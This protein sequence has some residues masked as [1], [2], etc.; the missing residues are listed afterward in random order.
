MNIT[1]KEDARQ[2]IE[3]VVTEYRQD[4]TRTN[5]KMITR[6]GY[7]LQ[8]FIVV[9]MSIMIF[10]CILK[11]FDAEHQLIKWMAL[12]GAG[13]GVI[14]LS[15]ILYTG[16]SVHYKEKIWCSDNVS[17]THVLYMCENTAL[18]NQIRNHLIQGYSITYSF[19]NDNKDIMLSRIAAKSQKELW[20][21]MIKKIDQS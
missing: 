8:G 11:Y 19:L 2:R 9:S 20:E 6:P 16:L 12:G 14:A 3:K 18:K 17:E 7:E 5:F 21:D 1:V 13:F 10:L 15:R 4:D